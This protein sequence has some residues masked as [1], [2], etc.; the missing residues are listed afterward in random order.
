MDAIIERLPYWNSLNERE[1]ESVRDTA[2]VKHFDG[3]SMLYGAD[4]FNCLGM[5]HVVSGELRAYIVSEEGREITLFRLCEGDSCVLSSSCIMSQ[6]DFDT[7]LAAVTDAEVLVI[8]TSVFDRL[9][10]ENIYVKCFMYELATER[11]SST[12]WVMQQM[13]FNG[14][15]RR[16]ASF[17]LN[18]YSRS[19][20]PEIRMTQEQIA[21]NVNSAREVVARMLKQFSMEGLVENRRGSI[22]LKDAGELEK[23]VL[24]R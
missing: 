23:I 20:N 15:D 1:R 21:R 16:L 17:L 12:I 10:D 8:P 9:T 2:V 6:I 7:M 11:F 19:G 14:F 22:L 5:I 13:L 4:G 3:G 18:E 24:G